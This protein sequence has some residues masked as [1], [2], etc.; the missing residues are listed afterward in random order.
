MKT[1][2]KKFISTLIAATLLVVTGCGGG[3]LTANSDTLASAD[4]TQTSRSSMPAALAQLSAT[5]KVTTQAVSRSIEQSVSR[6]ITNQ[7]TTPSPIVM[8]Q[9]MMKT[10]PTQYVSGSPTMQGDGFVYWYFSRTQNYIGIKTNG[11]IYTLGPDGLLKFFGYSDDFTCQ[12]TP[13]VC[14]KPILTKATADPIAPVY[15]YMA[16]TQR[17]EVKVVD[18]TGKALL[19]QTVT[20]TTTGGGWVVPTAVNQKTGSDGIASVL[21][22]YGDAATQ[23]LSATVSNLRGDKSTLT[24]NGQV[25]PVTVIDKATIPS[26]SL[27]YTVN[28]TNV[29]GFSGE[30]TPLNED[31]GTYFA[32]S[33]FDGYTGIARAGSNFD[34]QLQFSVWNVNGIKS[35]IVNSGKSFCRDFGHEGNGVMCSA[36]YPWAINKAYRFE[37]TTE[38][39][40][41]GYTDVSMNFVDVATGTRMYLGTLRQAKQTRSLFGGTGFF[42]EDY[43]RNYLGCNTVPEKSIKISNFK[44]LTTTGNWTKPAIAYT[45]FYAPFPT[46]MCSNAGYIKHPDGSMTIGLGGTTTFK[47]T[48]LNGG[49]NGV[50]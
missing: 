18:S 40:V 49:W 32:M 48:F 31:P 16:P 28:T 44:V 45:Q 24:F 22:V 19:D 14:I 29:T 3:D 27:H 47:T 50:Q 20:W 43:R 17:M 13:T 8:M 10:Y 7:S 46:T 1:S 21:W 36:E 2:H 25:K 33:W 41:A 30:M 5:E 26:S 39:V 12:V 4:I 6:G 11:E 9:W 34:R 23:T 38:N 37:M 15:A 35:S 42:A